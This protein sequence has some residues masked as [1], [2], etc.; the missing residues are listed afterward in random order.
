MC[1]KTLRIVEEGGGSVFRR[2][3]LIPYCHNSL[4][5]NVSNDKLIITELLQQKGR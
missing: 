2:G 4:L 5:I 1:N 3:N